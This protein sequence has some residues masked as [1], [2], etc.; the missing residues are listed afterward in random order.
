MIAPQTISPIV[1]SYQNREAFTPRVS[2]F[3]REDDGL[4]I[5]Q[6]WKVMA[7]RDKFRVQSEVPK[8]GTNVRLHPMTEHQEMAGCPKCVVEGS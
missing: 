3:R 2:T 4:D 6:D 8:L 5:R 7:R 1:C